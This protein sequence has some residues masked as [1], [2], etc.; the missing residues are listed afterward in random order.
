MTECPPAAMAFA[1]S[2]EKRIPP[3]AMTGTRLPRIARLTSSIA[4]SCGTPTPATIRVVQIEPGPIPTFTASQPACTSACAPSAVAT[5]PA[6]TCMSGKTLLDRPHPVDDALRVAVRGVHDDGV[7]PRADERLDPFV[8][9]RA[10]AHR[11]P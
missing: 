3:S 9:P 7:D 8:G 2:P 6:T 1:A 10:G 11:G 5:L 4:E